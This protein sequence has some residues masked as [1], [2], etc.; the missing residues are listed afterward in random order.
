[1]SVCAHCILSAVLHNN[2]GSHS[3]ETLSKDMRHGLNFE[4]E[5]SVFILYVTVEEADMVL[6]LFIVP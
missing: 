2:T 1:M 3:L 6:L 5:F 4:C